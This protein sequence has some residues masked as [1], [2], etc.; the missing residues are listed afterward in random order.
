MQAGVVI[1]LKNLER[2]VGIKRSLWK[3]QKSNHSKSCPA[4]LQT[5]VGRISE[6]MTITT[7]EP[8]ESLFNTL[9]AQYED[10][11]AN[12]PL[13]CSFIKTVAEKLPA[14]SKV[15]D[16]GCGTGKPVSHLLASAGHVVHGIDVSTEMVRLAGSQVPGGIFQQADMREYQ[17][18]Y[19]MDGVFAILSLFQL[20]PGDL[21][22][23]M[24]KFA[25]WVRE[26]GFVA[27]CVLPSTALA[28]QRVVYDPTWDAVWM[29]GKE[30]MGSLTNESFLSENGWERVLKEAGFVLEAEPMSYL[31]SPIGENHIPEAHHCLIARR[32][33]KRP[34]LGPFPWP[35][36]QM[37]TGV[38][39]TD[40]SMMKEQRLVSTEL[41]K[42]MLG[43]GQQNVFALGKNAKGSASLSNS[44]KLT[45]TRDKKVAGYQQRLGK[46]RTAKKS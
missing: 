8:A 15:L 24:Y 11:F 33:E 4:S 20:T 16:V 19:E 3:L 39:S 45:L 36:G 42:L 1:Y 46:F 31:F 32:V 40:G 28:P 2:G 34:L 29:I 37:M 17:P 18:P 23:M 13:L 35:S 14:N 9:G 41:E 10:A 12:D 26:D 38:C 7:A 22:S 6:N 43:L 27:L 21:V 5:S 25:E 30:W 44:G